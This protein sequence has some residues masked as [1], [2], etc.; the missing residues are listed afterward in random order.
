MNNNA[1][2]AG[3]PRT[4]LVCDDRAE[5]REAISRAISDLAGFEVVGEAV[6]SIS[7]LEQIR[8]HRPDILSVDVSMPGGGPDLIRAVKLLHSLVHIV[9]FSGRDDRRLHHEM[10]AA[11]ADQY[12]IKTGRLRPLIQAFERAVPAEHREQA[13]EI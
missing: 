2:D 4:L 10:L 5:V 11:G 7:C 3:V 8:E 1:V 6:D 9:V 13:P 12:V